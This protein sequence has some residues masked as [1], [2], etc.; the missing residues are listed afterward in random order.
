MKINDVWTLVEPPEE[1]KPIE[2]KWIFKRKFNSD[3][4]IDKYKTRIVAKG[5]TKKKK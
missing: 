1:D 5:F 4:S 2:C 3:G